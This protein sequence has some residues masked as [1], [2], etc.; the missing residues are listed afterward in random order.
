MKRGRKEEE[1]GSCLISEWQEKEEEGTKLNEGERER[2]EQ[3]RREK[4]RKRIGE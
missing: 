1:D 4:E 3:K 2:R